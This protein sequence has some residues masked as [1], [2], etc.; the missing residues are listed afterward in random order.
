MC[1]QCFRLKSLM[2][3]IKKQ[4]TTLAQG[5]RSA[6]ASPLPS[7]KNVRSQPRR[8]AIVPR[9]GRIKASP[10]SVAPWHGLRRLAPLWLLAPT[11]LGPRVRLCFIR[12]I[13]TDLKGRS[14]V[15]KLRSTLGNT[16]STAVVFDGATKC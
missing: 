8:A 3:P 13:H 7:A 5:W 10:N 1:W 2:T 16:R 4:K 6:W 14:V 11:H 12:P 9:G 15:L